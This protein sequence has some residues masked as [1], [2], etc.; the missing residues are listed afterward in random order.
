M[1][2]IAALEGLLIPLAFALSYFFQTEINLNIS[3]IAILQGLGWTIPVVLMGL[4]LTHKNFI[5]KGHLAELFKSIRESPLGDMVQKAS[6]A[7][8]FFLSLMAGV[9]EELVFRGVLQGVMGIFLS[10]LLFG[11]LHFLSLTYFFLAYLMSL[12]LS[13]SYSFHGSLAVPIIAHMVYDFCVLLRLRNLLS[14][15]R[16]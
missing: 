16:N 5:S 7:E 10:G 12:Y 8:L 2:K 11:L 14:G 6:A 4:L 1:I 3:L 9:G 13:L 15:P